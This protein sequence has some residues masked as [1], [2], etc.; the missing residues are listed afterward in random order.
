MYAEDHEHINKN[1]DPSLIPISNILG[2]EIHELA[3]VPQEGLGGKNHLHYALLD[4]FYQNSIYPKKES[5]VDSGGFRVDF[6]T[7]EIPSPFNFKIV[8]FA[9]YGFSTLFFCGKRI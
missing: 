3:L 4:Y 2:C 6:Y 5:I 9:G 1:D 8:Q 7:F